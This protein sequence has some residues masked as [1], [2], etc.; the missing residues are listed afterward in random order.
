MHL[1]HRAWQYRRQRRPRT[2]SELVAALSGFAAGSYRHGFY[3][4]ETPV[5]GQ[6][7]FRVADAAVVPLPAALP[8]LLTGLAGLGFVSRRRRAA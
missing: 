7:F 4:S 1:H 8:L 2:D 5:S 6:A 3:D